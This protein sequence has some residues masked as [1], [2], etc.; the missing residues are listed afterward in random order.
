MAETLEQL[1]GVRVPD[2]KRYDLEYTLM[3]LMKLPIIYGPA[4]GRLRD[5][6]LVL[7]TLNI[8]KPM[9]YGSNTKGNITVEDLAKIP[10]PILLIYEK[11]SIAIETYNVLRDHMPNCT[12]VFL[13][14]GKLKHFTILERPE[15][16]V[17]HIK[18]FL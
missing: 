18:A 12:S 13:P 7:R 17:E 6:A 3:Q 5:E 15:L 16:L 4:K 8:L 11:D 9:L 10:H 1:I 2:E 14:E